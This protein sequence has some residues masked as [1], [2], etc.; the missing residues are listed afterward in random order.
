MRRY[1]WRFH[2]WSRVQKVVAGHVDALGKVLMGEREQ[3]AVSRYKL[4]RQELLRA[5]RGLAWQLEVVERELERCPDP[6]RQ[7]KLRDRRTRITELIAG[8]QAR[9]K[10]CGDRSPLTSRRASWRHEE[11]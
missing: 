6:D 3:A 4:E 7:E 1:S 5:Y 2:G 9:L 8:A 11:S 10:A